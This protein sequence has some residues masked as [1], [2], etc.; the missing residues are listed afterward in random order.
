[1]SLINVTFIAI[2]DFVSR[3][4]NRNKNVLVAPRLEGIRLLRFGASS[5]ICLMYCVHQIWCKLAYVLTNF[6]QWQY[7]EDFQ[8][9][10]VLKLFVFRFINYFNS[11]FYLAFVKVA[12]HPKAY[13][14][15]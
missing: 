2:F 15:A 12:Q 7:E 10:L 14:L 1:M 9:S 4:S 6:E 11:F 13:L 5:S 8:Q 3:N